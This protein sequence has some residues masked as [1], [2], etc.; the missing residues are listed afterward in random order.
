MIDS[1]PYNMPDKDTVI[2]TNALLYF[3]WE[4]EAMR[5]AKENRFN[6]ALT[7]DPILSKYKFTNIRRKDDRV[8][9]WIIK[10]VIDLYPTENY[11]QDLWFVLLI[12]R[13]INWP[14]TLQHLIDEGILLQAAGDFDTGKFSKSIEEFRESLNGKKVYSGAYMVYPT[15]KDVGSVKSLSLARYIIEPTLDIGD[16]IDGSF[17]EHN[18]IADFVRVLS[19]CFGI[20]TFIAGQVA[21]DLTYGDAVLSKASDLYSYAPIGPG[22]SKGL[23]YLLGRG[24]YASWS[25]DDFN[26]ELMSINENIKSNLEITD[27]TLHDVQNVMCE[28]SKYTRTVLGEGKPKTMYRPEMEF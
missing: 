9:E 25:Q 22:S 8:S 4:R 15:K 14:P 6:G 13:L 5:I 27:L 18:S 28:Y 7:L 3:V 19:G 26:S 10:N 24:P 17:F 21:A 20:S 2:S 23:N 11:R 16:D 12:C 1:N